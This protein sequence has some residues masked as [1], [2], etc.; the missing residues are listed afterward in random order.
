M[1][2]FPLFKRNLLSSLKIMIIFFAVMTMYISVIIYMYDPALADM[3][4]DYQKAL[5]EMMN[6][7][8]MTG[9]ASNLIEFVH[10]YLYGFILLV[11]PM[12]FTIIE[13]NKLL[14][15][16]IDSGS[17]AS[18][19]A[20]P[21][22]RMKIL[23]TQWLSIMLHLA[24]LI[25][26]TTIVGMLTCSL[27]FPN[28]LDIPKYLILNG[29]LLLLHACIASIIFLAACIFHEARLFYLFGAGIPVIF[30][31]LQM[32]GNMGGDL[33]NLKYGSIFTL[34]PGKEIVAGD[35]TFASGA[36]TSTIILGV[37]ILLFSSIGFFYFKKKD[38]PL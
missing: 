10:I 29:V 5:P 28:E 30:Y 34:F 20:T 35:F 16:Y 26:S 24:I 22:S 1:I 25:A 8:G 32:L 6:A 15:H 31:L 19:L 9:I 33:E 36:I 37:L 4:N 2:S 27:L 3:L 11:F 21:N 18:L 23:R 14:T 12:V 17:F 7:V 38:L 13:V